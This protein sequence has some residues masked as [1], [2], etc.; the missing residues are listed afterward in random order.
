MFHVPQREREISY[1]P[2]HMSVCR[3]CFSCDPASSQEKGSFWTTLLQQLECRQLL[4]YI[5]ATGTEVIFGSHCCN[6]W[7]LGHVGNSNTTMRT[8]PLTE[9]TF[10]TIVTQTAVGIHYCDGNR[11]NCWV[12]LLQQLESRSRWEQ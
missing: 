8:K 12:T 11:G 3:S 10:A 2:V 1:G 7:N 6:N 5:T 9:H 4:E